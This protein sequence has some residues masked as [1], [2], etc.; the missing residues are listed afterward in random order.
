MIATLA[1]R[2]I[3]LANRCSVQLGRNLTYT[4]NRYWLRFSSSE[5]KNF[6]PFDVPLPGALKPSI[7]LYLDEVRPILLR[8]NDS[9]FLWIS[10]YGAP[11]PAQVLGNRIRKWTKKYLGVMVGPQAFRHCAVTSVAK[12]TPHEL[13]T[14]T[15]LLGHRSQRT[16]TRFYNHAG[17]L[18]AGKLYQAHIAKLRDGT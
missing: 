1:A 10:Q 2:P 8:S 18:E 15:A 12:A 9:N 4:D 6:L 17:S 3:R 7:E 14:A 11:L 5:T 16:M 13:H